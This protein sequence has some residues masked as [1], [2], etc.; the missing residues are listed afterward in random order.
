[1]FGGV[2]VATDLNFKYLYKKM[3]ESFEIGKGYYVDKKYP[4]AI[5]YLQKALGT[6]EI[7]DEQVKKAE[8]LYYL[9]HSYQLR[10][11]SQ[12]YQLSEDCYNEL[13]GIE[14]GETFYFRVQLNR[15]KAFVL[16]GEYEK[17]LTIFNEVHESGE[18]LYE[19]DT[20]T[21]ETYAYFCLGKYVDQAYF[22]DAIVYC[23]NIIKEADP[24]KNRQELF[25]A[26]HNLGHVYYEIGENLKAALAFQ[27][28]IE[29]CSNQK[30]KNE[31]MVDMALVYIRLAQY[32]LAWAYIDRAQSYFEKSH[33]VV[34]LADC[35]YAKGKL[36]KQR[37]R[38]E[39]AANYFDLALSG[40]RE[41]EYY[42][43]IL[44]TF[45]EL[46]E[47]YRRIN[48]GKADLYLDQYKFYLNYVNPMGIEP[49]DYAN[50]E[51]DPSWM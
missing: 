36:N 19:V 2:T 8:I 20:W 50:E 46:Y 48:L 41:Q 18:Q 34:A 25:I 21:I 14:G 39:E 42:F 43:G 35:L 11:T 30:Y 13:L 26:H 45:Y 4:K 31:N 28:S 47:L 32:D 29:F 7:L 10:N 15:A 17:A 33:D 24:D 51:E 22:Q 23:N 40:Y 6:C 37:G 27:D 3:D 49:V 5:E 9:G 16:R 38:I 12:D 1:M 44:N